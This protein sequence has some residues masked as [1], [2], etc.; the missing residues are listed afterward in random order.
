MEKILDLE[1]L[2]ADVCRI[3]REACALLKSERLNF[4]LEMAQEK[5]AHDY[6]SC[7]A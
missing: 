1:K 7:V 2:T 5:H 4:R 6:V 3:A